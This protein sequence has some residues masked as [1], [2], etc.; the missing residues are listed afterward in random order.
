[1]KGDPRSAIDVGAADV[2]HGMR[3]R[4]CIRQVF[5]NEAD[6]VHMATRQ[7]GA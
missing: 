3:R 4:I 5:R 7:G 1:V 6:A 2:R